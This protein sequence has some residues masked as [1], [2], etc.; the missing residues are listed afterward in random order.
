MNLQ[1]K[2]EAFNSA[3]KAPERKRVLK[4]ILMLPRLAQTLHGLASLASITQA[5]DYGQVPP[6]WLK[7]I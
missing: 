6:H 5:R 7:N 2:V 4:Q 3:N 1:L